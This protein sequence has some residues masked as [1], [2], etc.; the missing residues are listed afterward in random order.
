M[1]PYIANLL[2][3]AVLILMGL[4]GY[5]ET[6]SGTAFIPVGF[7][8][9]LALCTP[10]VRSENKIVAHVAVLLTLLMLLALLG[11]RL[12]KALPKGGA[13]LY[14]TLAMILT[15]VLA[16]VAF[17]RSFIAARKAREAAEG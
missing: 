12:P 9:V 16:M 13:G 2:N 3:A 10:G 7:G 11:M 17:I 15:S 6:N 4:W 14:R 8:V 5:M 1:K